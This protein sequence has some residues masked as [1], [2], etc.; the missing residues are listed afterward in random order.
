MILG[1]VGLILCFLFVASLLALIFGFVATRQIKRSGGALTGS[2]LARA[3]WIMGLIGLLVGVGFWILAATGAFDDGTTAVF[4]VEPGECANFD[5]DPADDDIEVTTVDVVNCDDPHESE[6]I[7][8]DELNPGGGLPY[9][10]NEQFD[11]TVDECTNRIPDEVAPGVDLSDYASFV[12]IPNED[13]WDEEDG[14]LVCFAVQSD[15]GT[16]TG[17]L[18]TG[19]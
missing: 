12:V 7:F 18:M 9:P 17:S 5:F 1:I 10:T 13:S 16:S 11:D 2:G 19:D 6:V 3:G 14:P 8:V 15:R 4:D